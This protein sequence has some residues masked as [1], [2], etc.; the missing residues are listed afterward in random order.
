MIIITVRNVMYHRRRPTLREMVP[1]LML[2]AL[3]VVGW[4]VSKEASTWNVDEEGAR[5]GRRGANET[6][7][8]GGFGLERHAEGFD[9]RIGSLNWMYCAI[10]RRGGMTPRDAPIRS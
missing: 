9:L 8:A 7:R 4:L 1:M 10:E 3:V 5:A 2:A 6:R